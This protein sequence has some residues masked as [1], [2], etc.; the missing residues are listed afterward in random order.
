MFIKRYMTFVKA[1]HGQRQISF[2]SKQF[3][4]VILTLKYDVKTLKNFIEE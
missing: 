2:Y 3:K 1:L 4:L